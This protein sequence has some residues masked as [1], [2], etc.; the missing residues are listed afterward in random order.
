VLEQTFR[1][2]RQMR[3]EA[4]RSTLTG[5]AAEAGVSVSTVSKVLNG[6][7]DVAAGTRDRIGRLLRSNGY[8]V[9]SGLPFGVADLLIGSLQGPWAEELIRGAVEAA[10]EAG[11]SIVV[12]TVETDAD[13]GHWLDRAAG[14]GTG[15]VLSVL[16]LPGPP[17]RRRLASAGI[18]L[19]VIDPPTEPG[20]GIRSV[21]TTNWQGGMA[22][23]RHLAELGH[24]R[25]AAIGGPERFWSAN[26]RLDGYRTALLRS[27]LP[28]DEALVGRGE[29]TIASGRSQALHLLDLPERP[30][31]I[32]AGNDNQAFGVLQALAERDLRAPDD[33]SVVG[34]DDVLATWATPPL[35]TVH[36]PL[37]AMAAAGFRMLRLSAGESPASPQH[38]ELATTLVIRDS[39]APPRY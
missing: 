37:A 38:I 39:T 2:E 13:F 33:V 16:H 34:F 11:Q 4:G 24:R 14:R 1:K 32:V 3:R 29:F 10:R 15:G 28:V 36:Q 27:G 31:A 18:P 23:T 12:T 5:I 26:A 35:T 25:I 8:R 30:T 17:E 19:V 22:A 21:G 20:T 6:R 9:A 7:T